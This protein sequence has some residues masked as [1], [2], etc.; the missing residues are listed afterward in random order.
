MFGICNL[1]LIPLRV[2]PRDTSEMTSQV[3]FGEI[4]EILDQKKQWTKIKLNFK[5]YLFLK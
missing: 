3:L 5:Q 1:S 4:F 2:E